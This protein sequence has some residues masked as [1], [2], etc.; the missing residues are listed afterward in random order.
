MRVLFIVLTCAALTA[1]AFA[2]DTSSTSSPTTSSRGGGRHSK[3]AQPKTDST[4]NAKADEKGYKAALDRVPTP[5]QKYDPWGTM[6]P[7]TTS[8]KH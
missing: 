3:G 6:R 5:T 4:T 7:T 2:D 8:D 1:P